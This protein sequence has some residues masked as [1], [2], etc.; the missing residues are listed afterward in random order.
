MVLEIIF[1]VC[2][3]IGFVTARSIQIADRSLGGH[4][5]IIFP[6]SK[7]LSWFAATLMFLGMISLFAILIW[8]FIYI[9]W[10]IVVGSFIFCVYFS[11]D[12]GIGRK[13][14]FSDKNHLILLS[15]SILLNAGLW[16]YKVLYC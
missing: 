15:T 9:K 14:P 4:Y 13:F 1:F 7:I 11:T 16:I 10:Y 2:L 5:Y 12:Y 8:G 3:L 6:S